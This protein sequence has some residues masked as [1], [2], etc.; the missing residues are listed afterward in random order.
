VASSDA[1]SDC[2][3]EFDLQSSPTPSRRNSEDDGIEDE[4]YNTIEDDCQVSFC[5]S[6]VQRLVAR[7]ND[8]DSH[9]DDNDD[10]SNS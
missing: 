10:K 2:G 7:K 8:D 5:L 6:L 9:V 3:S 1:S 4:E